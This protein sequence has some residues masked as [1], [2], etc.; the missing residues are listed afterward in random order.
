MTAAPRQ[1]IVCPT[2]GTGVATNAHADFL[3]PAKEK[4]RAKILLL[5]EEEEEE[6]LFKLSIS[7]DDFW[8]CFTF[9]PTGIS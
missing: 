7:E 6:D 3:S 8:V 2:Q 5:E 4:D 1:A 9:K